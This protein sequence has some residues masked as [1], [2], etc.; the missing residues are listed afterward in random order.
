LF[1]L[2]LFKNVLKIQKWFRGNLY[3]LKHLPLI[4]Y[5]IKRYLL[6]QNFSLININEDGRINSSIHENIII[7][8]IIIKFGDRIKK[9]KIRMWYDILFFDYIYG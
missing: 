9:P 2:Y 1:S 8:L 6:L 3:R 5:K 4:L 7:D